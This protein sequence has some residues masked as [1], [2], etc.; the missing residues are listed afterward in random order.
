MPC[1]LLWGTANPP[2]VSDRNS[3]YLSREDIG[4]MISQINT[5]AERIP[6][7]VEHKGVAVGHVVSAWEHHGKMECVLQLDDTVF[8]GA[9]G[10][11]FVR[12]GLCKDLSLGYTLSLENSKS[13]G[14]SVRKK[15]I[16]EISI[17]KKGARQQC[18]IHG[19]TPVMGSI[20][21]P[22]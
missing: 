4:D 20:K 10:G 7:H 11:E 18:H 8:E 21:K 12:N 22:K 15:T 16:K 9:L 5:T 17:V 1:T 19:V 14:I 13:G 3:V 2:G 6:V